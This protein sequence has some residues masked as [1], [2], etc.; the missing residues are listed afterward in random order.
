ML[1]RSIRLYRFLAIKQL[2]GAELLVGDTK[3]TYM[4]VLGKERLNTLDMHLGIL[5]AGTMTDINRELEHRETVALQVLA[6]QG[7]GLLVPLCLGR[8]VEE[9]KYPHNPV[10]AET[11]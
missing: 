7:I 8:K 5:H 4:S 3:Y 1:T 11:V 2:Y 10:F 9:N 6:E